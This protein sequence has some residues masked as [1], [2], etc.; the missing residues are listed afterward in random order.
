MSQPPTE[1]LGPQ[2][3]REAFGSGSDALDTFLKRQA[4]QEQERNVSVCWILPDPKDPTRIR[5]Y[6]TLSAYS[7]KLTDLPEDVRKR[8]PKYPDMPAAL[9]GR[10]AV[11]A[12]FRGQG[13][14]EHLL[15]DAMQ[16]VLTASETMGTL[17][18]VVDAK[19]QPAAEFYQ[20]FDFIPFPSQPLRLFLPLATIQR[21]L[22]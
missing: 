17:V 14:G 22:G 12:Q 13:H 8:L 20:H 5:G 21:L 6:Y 1:P 4:R 3:A 19:D 11:D 16:K 9:L 15:L 7:V 2:H 18:L 10:L